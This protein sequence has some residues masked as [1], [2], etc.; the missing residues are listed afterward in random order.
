VGSVRQR[1][2]TSA[3]AGIG[4]DRPG[5]P[6]SR[7]ERGRKSARARTQAV[8][9]RWGSPVRRRGR[10]RSLAGPSGP[11]W[12]EMAFSFSLE[13]LMAFLFYFH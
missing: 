12:A 6:G 10:A 13:F 9:G 7:R 8:A 5:P 2:G 4:A 11:G 3:C 1:E